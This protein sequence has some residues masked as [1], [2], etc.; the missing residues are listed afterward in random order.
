MIYIC[1]ESDRD[2]AIA[3]VKDGARPDLTVVKRRAAL[4]EKYM[5]SQ[6]LTNSTYIVNVKKCRTFRTCRKAAIDT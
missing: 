1:K 6:R 5:V 3:D 4:T 2:I